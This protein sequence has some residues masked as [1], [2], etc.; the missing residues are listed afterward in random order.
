[1]ERSS[2]RQEADY[3]EDIIVTVNGETLEIENP[4]TEST[5]RAFSLDDG[6]A[7]EVYWQS[8]FPDLGPRVELRTPNLLVVVSMTA[9]LADPG[10]MLQ[11]TYLNANVT[12]L[13]EPSK[14][15]EGILGETYSPGIHK[16]FPVYDDVRYEVDGY[17]GATLSQAM[18]DLM[19]KLNIPTASVTRQ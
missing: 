5:K 7:L 10:G 1:M 17:F 3:E 8:H 12:V 14:D 11:P 4:E 19:N 6:G 16:K 15:M 9:P 2:L 13:R 18:V